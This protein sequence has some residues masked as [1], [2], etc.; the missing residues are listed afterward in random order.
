MSMLNDWIEE[1]NDL[2]LWVSFPVLILINEFVI[3]VFF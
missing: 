1:L 2:F 3:Y